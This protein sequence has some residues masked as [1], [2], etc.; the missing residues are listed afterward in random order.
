MTM[1]GISTAVIGFFTGGFFS[2]AISTVSG[3]LG[4]QTPTFLPYKAC[5]CCP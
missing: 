4:V 2:D 1:V 3:L 5:D